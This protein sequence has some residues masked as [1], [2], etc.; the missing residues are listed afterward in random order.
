MKHP[1]RP[2]FSRRWTTPALIALVLA[3]SS[4]TAAEP[5]FDAW[6]EDFAEDWVRASPLLAT[7][8]QYFTGAE[9]DVVDRQLAL[10]NSFGEP[11]GVEAARARA[12]LARRG[13]ERLPTF[14]PRDLTPVQKTSAS[15]IR[16][17]LERAL[18]RAE[19]STHRLVF[20][21]MLNS[22]QV[23]LVNSLTQVHPIRSESDIQNYLARLG[24]VSVQID[25]GVAEARTAEAAGVIPPRFILEKT[26][27]QFDEFLNA[28]A[29]S[30]EFVR[31]LGERID[32]LPEKIPPSRRN[33]YV[34]EAERLVQAQVMPAYRRA[35][36]LLASQLAKSTDDAGAWRLPRGDQFY[37]QE[38]A[39]S[40]TT[41]LSAAEIHRI[42]LREVATI[43]AEMDRLLRQLGF[44]SGT[45][46]ER[47]EAL[48]ASMMAKGDDPRP[49]ILSQVEDAM[50]DAERRVQT[51]FGLQPKSP[52]I[53]KRE[54]SLSEASVAARYVPPAPDGSRP[55]TYWLPLADLGPRVTWLGAGLKSTAYHETVPG[56]HFQLAIQQES[57]TLP[58]FRKLGAFGFISAYGEG[59]ALYAERLADENG[60]YADDPRG[61][62]GYLYLQL[63]R[64]RRLVVDTGIHAMRWTRQQAI[65]YG[66]TPTEVER[67]VV[68]PGQACSYMIGQ[69]RIIEL[70]ERAR[71]ALGSGFSV[72][73]FH[74]LVLG[75]GSVPLDVLASEVDTWIAQQRGAEED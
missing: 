59:W 14:Q 63:F 47:V 27:G 65:D 29:A 66:I 30:N 50:R 37:A 62:V 61:R 4:V 28:P 67:Y 73:A 75:L 33:S 68:W 11:I 17:N 49:I 56:H 72:K 42:G 1:V 12:A 60:W 10:Y 58:K 51:I 57:E 7:R 25:E 70:R 44:T 21:Q 15:V 22:L 46:Q 34:S 43:E 26:I 71:S 24:Q 39:A 41:R 74:D 16:W 3:C 2:Y 45:L 64:A 20:H 18:E 55:G 40:T 54:P 13:L 8:T 6:A 36:S 35:R 23:D 52:V 32:T 5:S 53:V 69:L 9:Q 19:F 48:N 38:L 31:S